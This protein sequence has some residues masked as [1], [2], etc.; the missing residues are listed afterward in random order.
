MLG[1]LLV[2]L[3]EPF[4][5]LILEAVCWGAAEIVKGLYGLFQ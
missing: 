3:L 4:G 1:D 2:A 5:E